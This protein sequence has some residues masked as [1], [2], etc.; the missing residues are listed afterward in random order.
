MKKLIAGALLGSALLTGCSVELS[1]G[2][3]D[4]T[5]NVKVNAPEEEPKRT[6]SEVTAE[7]E[8]IS[9]DEFDILKNDSD[10]YQNRPFEKVPVH[11]TSVDRKAEQTLILAEYKEDKENGNT[12]SFALYMDGNKVDFEEGDH[13]YLSGI[14]ANDVENEF[15]VIMSVE[16][17]FTGF[18]PIDEIVFHNPN[19]VEYD[20][21]QTMSN[22]Y[23][24]VTVE[25]IVSGDKFT[26]VYYSFEGGEEEVSYAY[27]NAFSNG[28]EVKK[29]YYGNV[30][31]ETEIEEN[32]EMYEGL[33]IAQPFRI[34][35]NGSLD[36]FKRKAYTDK[37]VEDLVFEFD[38]FAK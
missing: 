27:A 24:S 1:E 36:M 21:N 2:E 10:A 22:D 26:I 6:V 19:L 15:F 25:R 35:I 5:V 8:L 29:T 12:V 38:G 4:G 23:V 33:D 18:E 11:I 20:I 32:H 31:M 9:F 7:G 34:E 17:V 16:S 14:V 3:A 37:N 13:G 28:Q 30:G